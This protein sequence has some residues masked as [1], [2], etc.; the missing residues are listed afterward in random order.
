MFELNNWLQEQGFKFKLNGA[1]THAILDR[2]PKCDGANKFYINLENGKYICHKCAS[3]DDSETKGGLIKLVKLLSGKSDSEVIKLL[4]LNKRTSSEE[5]N[6]LNSFNFSFLNESHFSDE[7]PLKPIVIPPIFNR[8]SSKQ[9]SM[10]YKYLTSRGLDCDDIVRSDVFFIENSNK[11]NDREL[12]LSSEEIKYYHKF[13]NRVIFPLKYNG[14]IYGLIARDYTGQSKLKVINS[15]N[16]PKKDLVWNYDNVKNSKELIIAEGIISAI[17]CGINRS[18]ATLSKSVSDEQI[19]K[20]AELG[21]EQVYICLD[22]DAVT[23]AELLYKRLV[24]F[25]NEVKVI[26]LPEVKNEKGEYL[27]AGDYTKEEMERFKLEA[28]IPETKYSITKKR[29]Y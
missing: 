15:N 23:E 22:V 17:K 21:F 10:A 16:L 2:C 1:K 3:Y 13:L 9:D 11:I 29:K 25:F 14:K 24:P 12:A 20:L 4:K 5:L 19:I 28:R 6:N 18:V 26:Y 27:D 8:A 7:K